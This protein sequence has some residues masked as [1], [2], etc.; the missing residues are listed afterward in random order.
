[1]QRVRW[2]SPISPHSTSEDTVFV[3]K[4]FIDVD[5]GATAGNKAD[6]SP[7]SSETKQTIVEETPTETRVC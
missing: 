6:S 2:P 4:P 3:D 7:A 1:M 5:T